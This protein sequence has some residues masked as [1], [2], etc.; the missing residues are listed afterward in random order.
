MDVRIFS[1]TSRPSQGAWGVSSRMVSTR[2]N[3][4]LA[5]MLA[6]RTKKKKPTLRFQPGDPRDPAFV[7]VADSAIRD[8]TLPDGDWV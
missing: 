8:S 5:L 3:P 6:L 2:P 7:M 4:S 1:I